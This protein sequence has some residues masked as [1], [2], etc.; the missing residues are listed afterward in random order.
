MES[1]YF[2]RFGFDTKESIA[3]SNASI[4]VASILRYFVNF[5][6]PHPL[7]GGKGVLVDY[8]VASIMLP[9]IVVGATLGTM[10]NKMLPS[11]AIIVILCIL[12]LIVSFTTLRKLLPPRGLIHLVVHLLGAGE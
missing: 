12:V 3:L 11:V 7:K 2:P 6:K 9:M 4:C 1:A 8:N 5:N 10:F